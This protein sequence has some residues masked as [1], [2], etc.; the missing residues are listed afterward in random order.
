MGTEETQ[1]PMMLA[2]IWL[3]DLARCEAQ[4]EG[5]SFRPK[6]LSCEELKPVV[7]R[8]NAN[9]KFFEYRVTPNKLEPLVASLQGAMLALQAKRSKDLNKLVELM[10]II[11]ETEED[12]EID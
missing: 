4:L 8:A 11:E 3:G 6:V 1:L 12:E 7:N 5:R 2:S 10:G 9:G